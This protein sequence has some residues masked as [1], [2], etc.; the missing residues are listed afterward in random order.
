MIDNQYKGRLAILYDRVLR[1]RKMTMDK[2]TLSGTST[3][4]EVTIEGTPNQLYSEGMC[5]YQMWDEAKKYFA[6]S[7]G[8]KRQPEVGTVAIWGNS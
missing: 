8:S 3:Y 1:H 4:V 6:A 2:L 5:A 7:P